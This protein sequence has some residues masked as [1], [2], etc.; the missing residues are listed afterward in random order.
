[1]AIVTGQN[2]I[3]GRLLGVGANP[4][5]LDRNGQSCLHLAVVYKNV[6]GLKTIFNCSNHPIDVDAMNYEG[7]TFVWIFLEWIFCKLLFTIA[8]A[9]PLHV[10]GESLVL[11]T[12]FISF[13]VF[14]N[15]KVS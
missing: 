11:H 12:N 9:G 4:N 13:S 14:D 5:L 3:A 7:S 10:W 15:S 2:E 8:P 1:M 6:V